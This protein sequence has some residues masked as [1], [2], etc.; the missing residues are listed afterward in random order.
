MLLP[1]QVAQIQSDLALCDLL[2]FA[3]LLCAPY[4]QNAL[5]KI[6]QRFTGN[7]RVTLVTPG[8]LRLICLTQNY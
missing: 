6:F 1:Q 5:L 7:Q 8:N 4:H 2:D 3:R